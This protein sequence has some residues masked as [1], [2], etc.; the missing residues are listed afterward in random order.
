MKEWNSMSHVLC[1]L[2]DTRWIRLLS[3]TGG[4]KARGVANSGIALA[5]DDKAK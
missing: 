1:G 5:I 2:T 3:E 4:L